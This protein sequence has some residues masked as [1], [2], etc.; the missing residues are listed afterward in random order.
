MRQSHATA[1]HGAALTMGEAARRA[2]YSRS[3]W[4]RLTTDPD[5]KHYDSGLAGLIRHHESGRPYVLDDELD[6]VLRS[7]CSAPAPD[8][9]A[10][11]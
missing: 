10:A 11:A 3:H 7:R 6:A 1:G 8:Q 5:S 9:T 4:Y 2:G